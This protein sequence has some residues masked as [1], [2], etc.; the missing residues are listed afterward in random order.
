MNLDI[1]VLCLGSVFDLAPFFLE[2]GWI[3]WSFLT[4][5]VKEGSCREVLSRLEIDIFVRG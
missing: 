4:F 2:M 1:G 5:Y 3:G